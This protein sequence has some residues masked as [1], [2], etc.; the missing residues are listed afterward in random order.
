MPVRIEYATTS[1]IPTSLDMLCMSRLLSHITMLCTTLT[2]S[3]AVT[4]LGRPD[5]PS[6]SMFSSPLLNSA[7]HFFHCAI[8]RLLNKGF[9]EVFMNF[10]GRHSFLTEV[11][12]NRSDF[13]F[14]R[15]R[16]CVVHVPSS[17]KSAFHKPP[18][19]TAC[20]SHSQCPSVRSNDRLTQILIQQISQKH[21][22]PITF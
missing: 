20:F 22:T 6:S 12:D 9:H 2:L 19:M 10:L 3:S 5:R 7:A 17:L 13:K 15:F 11:L 16:K 4:I 21:I 8:R 14:L 1:L 18:S